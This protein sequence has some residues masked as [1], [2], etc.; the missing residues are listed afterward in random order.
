MRVRA[1]GYALPPFIL[2]NA[3]IIDIINPG[4]LPEE[5]LNV[6]AIDPLRIKFEDETTWFQ[7]PLDPVMSVSCKN[8]I[9][10]RNVLKN[11]PS[12][13]RRGTVKE[14]WSQDDYEIEIAGL[15][16]NT[17]EDVLPEDYLRRLRNYCEAGKIIEVQSTLLSIFNI[18]RIVIEDYNFPHTRG[19]GNQ[20]YAIK[21]YS[22]DNFDLLIETEA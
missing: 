14:L 19:M 20:M 7:L 18:T 22:D 6:P 17:T 12:V 4:S 10:R 8:I 16:Q 1:S 2:N 15:L 21:C 9:V 3:R 11:S 5:M 13:L